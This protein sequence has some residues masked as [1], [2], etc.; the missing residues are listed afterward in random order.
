MVSRSAISRLTNQKAEHLRTIVESQEY[1]RSA[2]SDWAENGATYL[3]L[4]NLQAQHISGDNSLATTLVTQKL[5]KS[6]RDD[7]FKQA[8]YFQY[9]LETYVAA[10]L[11][12]K[13]E[14]DKRT[15]SPQ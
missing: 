8:P 3:E 6:N 14:I 12:V 5:A 15:M 9:L 7:I 13:F 2:G 10:A 4:V 11:L 1:G